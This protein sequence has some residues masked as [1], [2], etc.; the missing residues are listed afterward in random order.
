MISEMP[1][2]SS[3]NL[4]YLAMDYLSNFVARPSPPSKEL[5]SVPPME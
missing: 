2:Y 5:S 1:K 4:R 3:I